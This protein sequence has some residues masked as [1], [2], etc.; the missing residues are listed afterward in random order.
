MGRIGRL[1]LSLARE[2]LV[3]GHMCLRR[4]LSRLHRSFLPAWAGG[5]LLAVLGGPP[6]AAGGIVVVPLR[7]NDVGT[8]HV[9][10]RIGRGTA[11]EFL[12]DTGSAYVVLTETTRRA[13]AAEGAL[14][15]L[16]SLRA[17]MAN[18]ATARAQVYRVSSLRLAGGCEVRNFEAVVLPGARKDILGLSAL[19]AVAPFTVDLEPLQLAVDCADSAVLASSSLPALR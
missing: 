4:L 8:L 3:P 6:V 14:T 16:R 18:E 17:V 11:R 13:L 1:R 7:A 12:L 9:D 15:P 19:R 5:V 10:A 2:L